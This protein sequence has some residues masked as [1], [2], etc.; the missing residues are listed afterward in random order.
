MPYSVLIPRRPRLE[1]DRLPLRD[2]ER[3][4]DAITA[5]ANNPRPHGCVKLAGANY[6]R[7]RIGDYRVAYEIDDAAHSV[8]IVPAGHRRDVYR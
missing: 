1:I 3:V 8:T 6:S 4:L 5:L 7:I 2:A